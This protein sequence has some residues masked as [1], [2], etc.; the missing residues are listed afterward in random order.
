MFDAASRQTHLLD[1]LS[2]FVLR[3][4]EIKPLGSDELTQA[5]IREFA[6]EPT[7]QNDVANYIASLIPRLC[8]AG[9]IEGIRL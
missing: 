2:A 1:E 5:L 6:I 9:L 8:N 3:Q 7:D 4:L